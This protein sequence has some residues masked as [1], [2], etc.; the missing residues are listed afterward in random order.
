[1]T[2]TFSFALN[3]PIAATLRGEGRPPERESGSI[4]YTIKLPVGELA[5]LLRRHCGLA[6]ETAASILDTAV[7]SP[8]PWR[9]SAHSKGVRIEAGNYSCVSLV[10]EV[11]SGGA[12]WSYEFGPHKPSWN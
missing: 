8:V 11:D 1:M 4:C 2:P 9:V 10:I 5:H 12:V 6:G 3:S 7:N